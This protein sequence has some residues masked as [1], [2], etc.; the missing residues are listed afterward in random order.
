M[1]AFDPS[2]SNAFTLR[3][4]FH[5]LPCCLTAVGCL[6]VPGRTPDHKVPRIVAFIAGLCL[7]APCNSCITVPSRPR[8]PHQ[9]P[10]RSGSAGWLVQGSNP[11]PDG[12]ALAIRGGGAEPTNDPC[13]RSYMHAQHAAHACMTQHSTGLSCWRLCMAAKHCCNLRGSIWDLN[14]EGAWSPHAAV[15]PG[16]PHDS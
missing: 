7:L 3:A 16:L 15:D 14:P 6:Q 5:F 2:G 9:G 1:K 4:F 10:A 13:I 12:T 11:A 8:L